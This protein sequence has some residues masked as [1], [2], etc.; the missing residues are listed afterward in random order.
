MFQPLPSTSFSGKS[1][2]SFGEYVDL[3][4]DL[5]SLKTW[6]ISRDRISMGNEFV[7][8]SRLGIYVSHSSCH[9]QDEKTLADYEL[10]KYGV[11]PAAARCV[12]LLVFAVQFCFFWTDVGWISWIIDNVM[13][14]VQSHC[15]ICKLLQ[16]WGWRQ[17]RHPRCLFRKSTGRQQWILGFSQ[18]SHTSPTCLFAIFVNVMLVT[19]MIW[20]DAWLFDHSHCKSLQAEVTTSLMMLS[21]M[22]TG[23]TLNLKD[24]GFPRCRLCAT[25][26]F[27]FWWLQ[28]LYGFWKG[29]D[30]GFRSLKFSDLDAFEG[31]INLYLLSKKM[32]LWPNLKLPGF[33]CVR[34]LGIYLLTPPKQWEVWRSTTCVW[35]ST[36]GPCS[37]GCKPCGSES[38]T[39]CLGI[40]TKCWKHMMWLYTI[41]YDCICNIY[42]IFK[43]MY[44]YM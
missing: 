13:V 37:S 36:E 20:N 32:K 23:I 33:H 29:E 44:K 25:S 17:I 15:F 5:E 30:S 28:F 31:Y 6:K 7:A 43:Y 3:D 1:L 4:E 35:R 18:L 8:W 10:D 22:R 34:D 14:S 16:L 11:C 12:S 40:A 42:V 26:F 19:E 41:I 9:V 2:H 24:V 21:G 38:A 39:Q 27:F